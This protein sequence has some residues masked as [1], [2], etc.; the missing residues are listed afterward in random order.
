M[1]ARIVRLVLLCPALTLIAAPFSF[2]ATYATPNFA[3][4]AP[5]AEF[6]KQCA[7]T[8][9][10]C[11]AQLAREWLGQT[12]RPW[13]RPCK[14]H[15]TVGQIGAGGATTFT[16]ALGEVYGWNMNIQGTPERILDS[17]IPHEVSHTIFAS[18]FRRPLPRWA[19]EGAATLVEHESERRRQQALLH[20]VFHSPR[21][22]PLQTLLSMKEYPSDMQGVLTLYAQG[23]SLADYLVQSG[24]KARYLSFLQFAHDHNN[25]N[26]AIQTHYGLPSV[27]SL[28]DRWSSWVIAGSPELEGAG[29]QMVAEAGAEARRKGLVIRSQSPDSMI[30]P[31]PQK[32][33]GRAARPA[34]SLPRTEDLE[35]PDPTAAA[36]PATGLQNGMDSDRSQ[37]V[38]STAK[39]WTNRREGR[40][41]VIQEGWQPIVEP[42]QDATPRETVSKSPRTTRAGESSARRRFEDAR[43]RRTAESQVPTMQGPD[44][45]DETPV[46]PNE[47][48]VKTAESP[49]HL[50]N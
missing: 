35:A 28:E 48:E 45:F 20:Q 9:E 21:R 1:D 25:W 7:D 10:Y 30:T 13:F 24:G 44:P 38:A 39:H 33:N 12:L 17:V 18:Y 15:V 36:T 2:G 6:A 31:L 22:I 50:E 41:R 29:N 49:F 3:V 40:E 46:R 5:S 43:E 32:Q 26:Q 34:K 14:V 47:L 42:M 4:T 16:F 37:A 19:D 23:Y 27:A 8:A 11:R